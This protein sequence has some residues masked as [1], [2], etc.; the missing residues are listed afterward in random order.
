M[1]FGEQLD[2]YYDD[3]RDA[4]G[5]EMSRLAF[6]A[7]YIFDF[8]AYDDQVEETFALA[9]L[10]VLEC[11]YLGKTFDYL[12]VDQDH[13]VNYLMMANFPFLSS[14]IEW[15]TSIRGAWIDESATP[16]ILNIPIAKG[17]LKP[18]IGELLQWSHQLA[19]DKLVD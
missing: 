9:M 4:G 17:Q 10:P 12:N 19:T 11:I 8:N 13:Y 16:E 6:I 18:F 2:D 7:T 5:S 1:T 3:V 14:I 15:G